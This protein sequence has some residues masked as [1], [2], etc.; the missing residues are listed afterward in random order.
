[1]PNT[2]E[3]DK[4]RGPSLL[5]RL[6]S[7]ETLLF[8]GVPV[9]AY[10]TVFAYNSGYF[11]VFSLPRQ[12]IEFN[13]IEVF[14]V[15]GV[16]LTYAFL[17]YFYGDLAISAAGIF[18]KIVAIRLRRGVIIFFIFLGI[19][20]VLIDPRRPDASPWFL[21]AGAFLIF[22]A[23]L[24]SPLITQRKLK[25]YLNKLKAA[26]AHRKKAKKAD[27]WK[28]PFEKLLILLGPW[29]GSLA[30]L[31]LI[32]Y[33][34]GKLQAVTQKHYYVSGENLPTAILW[35]GRE[36][37]VSARFNPETKLLDEEFT[38]L[39]ISELPPNLRYADIGP[40]RIAGTDDATPER[41]PSPTIT[42]P[43]AEETQAAAP[44]SQPHATPCHGR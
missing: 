39:E 15:S 26:E 29:L 9:A 3:Q 37:A 41:E 25:G 17:V 4:H 5:G 43:Q 22:G 27:D 12:L 13:L 30:F 18:P 42:S 14:A 21:A 32:V 10:L 6:S 35:L 20:T 44:I 16:I 36:R 40:L 38:I 1:M 28:S 19:G 23:E 33:G 31:L 8:A 7:S 2:T 34:L 24:G 11:A